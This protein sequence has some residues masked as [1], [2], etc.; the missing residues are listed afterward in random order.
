MS[1]T[2]TTI[3]SP[4]GELMPGETCAR[5][6]DCAHGICNDPMDGTPPFCSELCRIDTDCRA[7]YRDCTGTMMQG[8]DAGLGQ[9]FSICLPPLTE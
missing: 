1:T 9:N 6:E 7:G 4:I 5:A 2:H 8:Q 3:Q